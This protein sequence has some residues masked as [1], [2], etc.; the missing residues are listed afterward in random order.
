V[1]FFEVSK[2]SGSYISLIGIKELLMTG[3]DSPV[4]ILSF[5]MQDPVKRTKSQGI[6]QLFGIT[7][8][9]PGTKSLLEI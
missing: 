9:S 4:S 7:A 8:I 2:L 6:R 3:T 5:T 1:Y